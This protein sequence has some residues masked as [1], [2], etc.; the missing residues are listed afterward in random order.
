MIG[1]EPEEEFD[2]REPEVL[3]KSVF[4]SRETQILKLI[5]SGKKTREIACALFVDEKTVETHRRNMMR[6]TNAKNLYGVIA[7]SFAN[8]ILTAEFFADS[9]NT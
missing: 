9:L 5:A 8:E 2:V 1:A 7:Y 3:T 4:T 6:K